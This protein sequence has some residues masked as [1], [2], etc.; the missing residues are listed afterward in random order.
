MSNQFSISSVAR[1]AG[2]DKS[3]VSRVLAGK[4][5]QGRICPTTQERIRTAAR[6]LGYTRW[7]PQSEFRR[8]LSIFG[9]KKGITPTSILCSV[10]LGNVSYASCGTVVMLA[11]C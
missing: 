11:S 10:V 1:A 7:R 4:A 6:Q 9:H 3:T 5:R 8:W 2:G